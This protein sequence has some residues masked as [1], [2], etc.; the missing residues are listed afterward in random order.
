MKKNLPWLIA[1]L[2][3]VEK[4][5]NII[6][7]FKQIKKKNNLL[8]KKEIFLKKTKDKFNFFVGLTFITLL[9]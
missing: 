4:E 7:K 5:K 6:I 1:L 8:L 2:E 3:K 9:I